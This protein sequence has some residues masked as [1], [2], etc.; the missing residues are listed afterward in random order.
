MTEDLGGRL[1][2]ALSRDEYLGEAVWA[3]ECERIFSRV[4]CAVGR[5]EDVAETGAYLRVEVAGE[6]V[7]VTRDA[8]GTL[9]AFYNVC[10]HRG[11]R[12]LDEPRGRGLRRILCPYHAWSYELDGACCRRRAWTRAA[13]ATAAR[14]CASTRS[15]S[16]ICVCGI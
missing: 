16:S 1:E 10:R 4:W 7:L 2:P 6:S 11:S 14:S 3:R 5:E 12:L 15:R 8:D 9:R 13:P